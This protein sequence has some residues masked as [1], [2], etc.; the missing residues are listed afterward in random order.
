MSNHALTVA[1]TLQTEFPDMAVMTADYTCEPN[2]VSCVDGP[3]VI[4]SDG[5][6]V[7]GFTV[8]VYGDEGDDIAGLTRDVFKAAQKDI[9]LHDPM[10]YLHMLF[11]RSE[12]MF[13]DSDFLIGER[14]HFQPV[15]SRTFMA[16]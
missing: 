2:K 11:K 16:A 8:S 1:A 12:P 4:V 6:M 9:P 3:V 13:D 5:G 14:M 15:E 7:R 10:E